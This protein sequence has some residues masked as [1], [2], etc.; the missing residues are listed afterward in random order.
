MPR[1][2]RP[3]ARPPPPR[4]ITR[5]AFGLRSLGAPHPSGRHRSDVA[6]ASTQSSICTHR[7]GATADAAAA[8]R[9]HRDASPSN[10]KRSGGPLGVRTQT[11]PALDRYPSGAAKPGPCHDAPGCQ[12]IPPIRRNIVSAV[13]TTAPFRDAGWSNPD[14]LNSFFNRLRLTPGALGRGRTSCLP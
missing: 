3:P 10:S 1:R 8:Q 12:A 13:P 9:D 6:N 14:L 4:H 7:R 11:T 5:W 2:S